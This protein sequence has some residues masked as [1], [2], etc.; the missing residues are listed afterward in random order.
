VLGISDTTHGAA[1]IKLIEDNTSSW[2]GD[3]IFDPGFMSGVL[4]GNVKIDTKNHRGIDIE[5]TILDCLGLNQPD[6]TT[7]KSL[8]K[9]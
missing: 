8:L 4:L 7:G 6:Y 1:P 3:H 9:T 2:S 5:P